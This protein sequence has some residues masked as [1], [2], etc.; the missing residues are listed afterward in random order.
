MAVLLGF[1]WLGFNISQRGILS[2]IFTSKH[3]LSSYIS[4]ADL[5]RNLRY[6]RSRQ[7]GHRQI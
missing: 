1:F 7:A 2:R 5:E 6:A 4:N 3:F